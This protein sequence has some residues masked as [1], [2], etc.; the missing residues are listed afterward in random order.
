MSEIIELSSDEE[1]N[2][3][4]LQSVSI[5]ITKEMPLPLDII[6]GKMVYNFL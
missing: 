3:E 4:G 6:N 1:E 2:V 5:S